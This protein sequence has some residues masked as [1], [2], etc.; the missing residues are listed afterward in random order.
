MPALPL[1]RSLPLLWIASLLYLLSLELS[2]PTAN[3]TPRVLCREQGRRSQSFETLA[4][5]FLIEGDWCVASEQT[6]TGFRCPGSSNPCAQALIHLS[7]SP[8]SGEEVFHL[9]N[10]GLGLL[11]L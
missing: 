5:S 1:E 10:V 7:F 11:F 6:G 4:W 9:E 8:L 2:S 3:P